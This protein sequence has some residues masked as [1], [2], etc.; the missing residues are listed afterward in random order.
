M[1]Y[2]FSN[3][4]GARIG[5]QVVHSMFANGFFRRVDD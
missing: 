3:E 2:D 5:Q 4:A 1:H